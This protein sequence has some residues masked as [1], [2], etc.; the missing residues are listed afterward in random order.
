MN[1]VGAAVTVAAVGAVG[2]YGVTSFNG[3]P[4]GSPRCSKQLAVVAAIYKGLPSAPTGGNG[5]WTWTRPI[6]PLE[7]RCK[8]DTETGVSVFDDYGSNR[9]GRQ[10]GDVSLCRRTHAGHPTYVY[11]AWLGNG[12]ATNIGG[13][14][15]P[16]LFRSGD[17]RYIPEY[18][19]GVY[20]ADALQQ[21]TNQGRPGSP[22][23]SAGTDAVTNRNMANAILYVCGMADRG[24]FGLYVPSDSFPPY[25]NFPQ[26]RLAWVVSAL[27]QCTQAPF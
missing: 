24:T 8:T 13:A 11:L 15:M 27:N 18:R 16:E 14:F 6:R 9:P 17:T 26:D 10:V 4:D 22:M 2:T 21:W 25:G 5:C 1:L 20:N 19:R 3:G 12:W 7:A 23:V